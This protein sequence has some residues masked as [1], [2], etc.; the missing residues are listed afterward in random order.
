M[1]PQKNH[2]FLLDVFN[3][4]INEHQNSILVLV[5]SGDLER[6]IRSRIYLLGLRDNVKLMGQQPDVKRFYQAF[7][8]LVMP[9]LFEGFGLA[10]VEAQCSGLPCIISDKF[11]SKVVCADNVT[12]LPLDRIDIW[13]NTVLDSELIRFNDG[14]LNVICAG[15]SLDEMGR[16]FSNYYRRML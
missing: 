6:E 2:L 14:E 3:T 5:G 12:V 13:R 8:I 11:P 9:S 16:N 1:K 4:V 15:L 7:D 10:A